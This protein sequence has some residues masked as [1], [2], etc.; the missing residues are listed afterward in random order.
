MADYHR[1]MLS[2]L[3]AD[4]DAAD[5]EQKRLELQCERIRAAIGLLEEKV[6][7][8]SEEKSEV[9]AESEIENES[10]V[11]AMMTMPEAIQNCLSRARRPLL[12]RE[13]MAM[14]ARRRK[15]AGQAL[16]PSRVQHLVPIEQGRWSGATRGRWSLE[17]GARGYRVG[18]K[19]LLRGHCRSYSK[20]H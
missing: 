13:L 5:S 7:A 8:A 9:D 14:L 20:C 2:E 18:P 15:V 3:R 12:K 6:Q 1:L 17:L 19:Q 11:F 16:Q 10:G 4:L